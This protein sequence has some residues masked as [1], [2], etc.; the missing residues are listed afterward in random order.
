MKTPIH[1]SSLSLTS[2]EKEKYFQALENDDRFM[3][4]TLEVVLNLVI[5]D[6]VLTFKVGDL[7]ESD[8]KNLYLVLMKKVIQHQ[9]SP[10]SLGC[11]KDL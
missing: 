6:P 1:K 4:E 3:H 9:S 2:G 7:I 10:S 5:S 11:C 8:F